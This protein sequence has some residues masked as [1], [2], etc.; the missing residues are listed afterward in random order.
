[1]RC[2]NSIDKRTCWGSEPST[3]RSRGPARVAWATRQLRW[4][5]VGQDGSR[6]IGCQPPAQLRHL[7]LG[8]SPDRPVGARGVDQLTT[9]RPSPQR[10]RDRCQD[11]RHEPQAD[12]GATV[13]DVPERALGELDHLLPSLERG[14]V[15][16]V[17]VQEASEHPPVA[18]RPA[19]PTR[20]HAPLPS[21]PGGDASEPGGRTRSRRSLR[22]AGPRSPRP[23]HG[24]GCSRPIPR[25]QVHS[26]PECCCCCPRSESPLANAGPFHPPII[27]WLPHLT[28]HSCD[29]RPIR[30]PGRSPHPPG[31]RRSAGRGSRHSQGRLGC[32]HQAGG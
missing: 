4:V 11:A 29:P 8:K 19:A 25:W 2:R 10:D 7:P 31:R 30:T 17:V 20:Q 23:P 1:M 12:R 21:A 28:Y 14:P 3:A 18:F 32:R 24:S 5:P 9:P 26:R 16:Q 6:S 22:G 27:R 15:C 13:L